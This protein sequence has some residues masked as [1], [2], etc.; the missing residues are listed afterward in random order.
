MKS[1]LAIFT[2]GENLP[3]D[4]QWTSLISV[5]MFSLQTRRLKRHHVRTQ[6]RK[7]GKSASYHSINSEKMTLLLSPSQLYSHVSWLMSIMT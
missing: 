5:P 2:S 4:F 7:L 1:D 6:T 3:P